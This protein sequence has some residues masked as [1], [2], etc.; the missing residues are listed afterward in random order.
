MALSLRILTETE[1][2]R[3]ATCANSAWRKRLRSGLESVKPAGTAPVCRSV[4]FGIPASAAEES[5][6]WR[7]GPIVQSTGVERR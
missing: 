2:G 3:Q 4:L 1:Y 7:F 6:E 5:A